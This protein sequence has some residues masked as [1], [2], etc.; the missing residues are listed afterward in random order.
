MISNELKMD[1]RN[2]I[3]ETFS[4]RDSLPLNFDV[5]SI[6]QWDSLG[7]LALIEV[8]EDSYRVSFSHAETVAMLNEDAIAQILA[9]KLGV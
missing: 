1:V 7:H 8:I 4:L 3:I 5:E 6:N 2:L 9:S